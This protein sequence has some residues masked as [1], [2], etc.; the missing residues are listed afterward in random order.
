MTGNH[1]EAIL[2]QASAKLDKD[3]FLALPDGAALTL[4]VAHDGASLTIPK[5]DGV[6]LDG[7]LVYARTVKR[8]TYTVVQS[9]LFA[10][11]VD[12]AVGGQPARRAGFA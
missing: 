11:A 10:L 1:L 9:D 3:G 2:K 4:Y 6:R 8:E 12:G 7:E 5:V